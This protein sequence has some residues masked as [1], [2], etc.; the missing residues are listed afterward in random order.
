MP[1][2]RQSGVI[3]ILWQGRS[4]GFCMY[5]LDLHVVLGEGH[6]EDLGAPGGEPAC[7]GFRECPRRVGVHCLAELAWAFVEC[8]FCRTLFGVRINT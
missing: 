6:G 1:V 7:P 5:L 4:G 8:D 3:T 2:V